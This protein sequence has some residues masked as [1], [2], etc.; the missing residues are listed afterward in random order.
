MARGGKLTVLEGQWQPPR[1]VIVEF[2]TRESAEDWYKSP[3]SQ[4]IINL[5]LESTRGALVILDGM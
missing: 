4:R 2:P 1:T 5:R 3:D